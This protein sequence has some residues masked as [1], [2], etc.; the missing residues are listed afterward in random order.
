MDLGD[1]AGKA[2][3]LAQQHEDKID[4]AV[5]KVA[6]LVKDRVEG[7]DDKIDTAAAKVKGLIG[8]ADEESEGS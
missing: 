1:L 8:Q 5:D 7:H 3:D 6:D 2:K 4:D